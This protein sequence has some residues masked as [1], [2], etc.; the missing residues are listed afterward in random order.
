VPT[1]I[2]T[3]D[4]APPSSNVNTGVGGRG[5]PHGIARTKGKWEGIYGML[6]LAAKVPRGLSVV[7]VNPQLQF[8]SKNRRDGDNFYFPISKPLGDCLV[9]GGWLE[10]DTPDHYQCERVRIEVGADIR[11][12]ARMT[13]E[14]EYELPS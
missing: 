7:R 2:L 13:L 9:R 6:L 11:L 4:D 10:D 3:Y 5:N 1:A 14:I 8:R 12:K